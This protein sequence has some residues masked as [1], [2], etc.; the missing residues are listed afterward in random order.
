MLLCGYPPFHHENQAKLFELIKQGKYQFDEPYWTPI[1]DLAKDLIKKLLVVQ[2]SKRLTIEQV[3]EHD[4]IKNELP[5]SKDITP[6]LAELRANLSRRKVK[7]GIMS[8]L[9]LTK[10]KN[11]VKKSGGE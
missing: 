3:L 11:L 2:A 5:S 4:W 8:A 9:A 10:V 7:T 6:A 1:S